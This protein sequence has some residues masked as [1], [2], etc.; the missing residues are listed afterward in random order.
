MT[1]LGLSDNLKQ[2]KCRRPY[3]SASSWAPLGFCC[4]SFFFFNFPSPLPYCPD[5][6]KLWV[7]PQGMWTGHK[8]LAL[9]PQVH[10]QSQ[11]GASLVPTCLHAGREHSEH[12]S[13][14]GSDRL[15][16]ATA[17]S[18]SCRCCHL[19]IRAVKVVLTWKSVSSK[20]KIHVR[21]CW[22]HTDNSPSSMKPFLSGLFSNQWPPDDVIIN[23]ISS[24]LWLSSILYLQI[25]DYTFYV[26]K[27]YI[28][29]CC[30]YS[31]H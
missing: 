10:R 26:F 8:A 18:F 25:C 22:S 19:E 17:T 6:D 23:F 28:F 11:A 31:Y 4:L 13:I 24:N 5:A 29:N 1:Q 20:V 7:A 12:S 16:L 14:G 15:P 2:F 27:F 30:L 21:G 3:K 9:K